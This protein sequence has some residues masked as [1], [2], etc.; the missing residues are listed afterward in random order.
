MRSR[1]FHPTLAL[2]ATTTDPFERWVAE[3]RQV[4]HSLVVALRA[5]HEMVGCGPDAMLATSDQLTAASRHVQSW[6]PGH[7]CPMA[8]LD[9]LLVRTSR[10]FADF[11]AMLEVEATKPAEPHWPAIDREMTG[12]YR[13]LADVATL[14]RHWSM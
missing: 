6:L 14:M 8:D 5:A 11:G 12:L 1:P 2:R 4:R 13:M 9:G 7:R 3:S 10:S